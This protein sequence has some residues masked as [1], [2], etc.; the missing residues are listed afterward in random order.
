M[1]PCRVTSTSPATLR[2]VTYSH[3]M[4]AAELRQVV[5]GTKAGPIMTK[6]CQTTCHFEPQEPCDHDKGMGGHIIYIYVCF[7]WRLQQYEQ[8][9]QGDCKFCR[10]F[11]YAWCAPSYLFV[12]SKWQSQ[13]QSR[14]LLFENT[15]MHMIIDS[16]N[17]LWLVKFSLAHAKFAWAS[18]QHDIMLLIKQANHAWCAMRLQLVCNHLLWFVCQ[19]WSVCRLHGHDWACRWVTLGFCAMQIWLMLTQHSEFCS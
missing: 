9:N 14:M 6:I 1:H 5:K 17:W 18:L 10:W 8:Y 4:A 19:L 7:M 11:H 2:T 3:V 13:C 15:M 12:L 16:L